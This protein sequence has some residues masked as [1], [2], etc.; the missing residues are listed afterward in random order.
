MATVLWDHYIGKNQVDFIQE[1]QKQNNP[2]ETSL[3][4]TLGMTGKG[5]ISV[6]QAV[7]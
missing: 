3:F 1:K 5:A 2:A 6:L 7:G 4:L